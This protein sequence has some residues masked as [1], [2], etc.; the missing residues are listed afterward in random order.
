MPAKDKT[1]TVTGKVRIFPQ[2]GGWV[3]LPIPQKYADIG[4]EPPKWGLVPARI[5]IG[6]TTW[7]KSLLPMGDG[8]LFIALNAKV[9]KAEQIH[10]GD[11]VTA[12]F[13]LI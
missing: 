12:T 10:I 11:T 2:E 6:E 4:I 5:T 13:V 7:E 8:T 3:Y 9:R 1:Y